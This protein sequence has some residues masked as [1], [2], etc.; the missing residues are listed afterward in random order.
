[1]HSSLLLIDRKWSERMKPLCMLYM[2]NSNTPEVVNHN[3]GDK[4]LRRCPV[5]T[6]GEQ[7]ILWFDRGIVIRATEAKAQAELN[8]DRCREPLN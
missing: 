1:M 6:G 8:Y 7:S 5:T 3:A 4:C 2:L